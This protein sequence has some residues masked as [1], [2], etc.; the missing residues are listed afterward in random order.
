MAGAISNI[1]TKVLS[2]SY[3]KGL[4]QQFYTSA[5]NYYHPLMRADRYVCVCFVLIR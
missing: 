3:Y 4:S 1:V 5:Y 2:P